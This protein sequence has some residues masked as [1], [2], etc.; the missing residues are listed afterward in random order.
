M[1]NLIFITTQVN[2][3][4]DFVAHGGDF[5]LYLFTFIMIEIVNI[6]AAGDLLIIL[7]EPDYLMFSLCRFPVYF[8]VLL[9][10]DFI[11]HYP[12]TIVPDAR[13]CR[14]QL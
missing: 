6:L 3:L 11:S 8:S 13:R 12:E 4:N 2:H 7:F 14:Q 5:S 9:M 10:I 1:L